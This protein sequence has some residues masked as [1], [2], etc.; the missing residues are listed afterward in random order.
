MVTTESTIH[1]LSSLELLNC[2]LNRTTIDLPK[3]MGKE[4][5]ALILHKKQQARN[6]ES[7]SNSLNMYELPIGFQS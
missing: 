3:S 6:A 1:K 7:D 2:E 5:V 4:N